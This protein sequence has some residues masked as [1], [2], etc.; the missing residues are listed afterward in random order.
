M[1]LTT[2]ARKGELLYLKWSDI[3]FNKNVARLEG[4]RRVEINQKGTKNGRNRLL[5]LTQP[6]LDELKKFRAV[7]NALIFKNTICDYKPYEI[8]K[9]Y[10]KAL[11][12]SKITDFR[13]H[14][15]RHTAASNLAKNGATL[16]EIAEVLG[17]SNIAVTKRYSHLCIEHK[18]DLINKIMGNLA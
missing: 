7:G 3:D 5:C 17:H 10:A 12:D 14:D 15:L 13:F 4:N 16:L 6:V 1:A 9:I 2:G 11:L 8:R 18:R